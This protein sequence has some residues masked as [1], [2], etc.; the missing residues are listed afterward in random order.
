M[1]VLRQSVVCER[2][3]AQVSL[4][5]DGE[6]SQLERRMLAAHL[7]RC[8]D[9]REYA[10]GVT[11]FTGELR[12]APLEQMERSVV[13]HM[14]RRA[15]LSR[16]RLGLAAAVAIALV[17]SA[18]QLPLPGSERSTSA[19]TPSR[20]PTLSDGRTEMQQILADARAFDRHRS[21]PTLVM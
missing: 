7:L 16:V 17:G 9:C 2:V 6:L 8:P 1:S 21:G 12:A 13:V 15:V 19:R 20:F 10:E 14:P 4:E 3:R 5:L 18:L 11:A